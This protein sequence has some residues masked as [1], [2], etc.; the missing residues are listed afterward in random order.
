M[1]DD[2]EKMIIYRKYVELIYYVNQLIQKYPKH[3]RFALV[4]DTKDV[5]YEGLKCVMYAQKEFN[6]S[7][8][9]K[10]LSDLDVNLKLQKVFVRIAFKSE[11]ISSQNYGA[12]SRKITDVSNLLGGWIKS[13]QL[14]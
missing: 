12:W 1:N 2:L 14:Q 7:S 8:R 4:S 6:K 11:Y 13:C 9:L 3:E 10:I 5:L